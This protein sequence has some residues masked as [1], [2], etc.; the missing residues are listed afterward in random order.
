MSAR[1]TSPAAADN[2]VHA[3]VPVTASIAHARHAG[4]EEIAEEA[5]AIFREVQAAGLRDD[6]EAGQEAL[7]KRIQDAHKDFNATMPLVVRWT[8]QTKQYR[9]SALL[10]F[11]AFLRGK[12]WPDRKAYLAGQGEY[13]VILYK[14]TRAHYD[15][16]QVAEY[17]QAVVKQL[18][19]EDEEFEKLKTEAEEELKKQEAAID[20]ER[21]RALFAFLSKASQGPPAAGAPAPPAPAAPA[22]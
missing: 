6:D 14:E 5:A 10:R 21:R 12:A 22:Q 1:R 2:Y 7:L 18:L 13:L 9:R 3:E 4:P 15:E 20:G 17:R 16:R 19:D 8:V 11:V